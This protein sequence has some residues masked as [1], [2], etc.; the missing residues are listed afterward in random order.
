LPWIYPDDPRLW[1]FL[2]RAQEAGARPL[3]VA[4]KVAPVTFPLLKALGAYAL[5]YHLPLVPPNV[6]SDL[7]RRAEQFGWPPISVKPHLR[8]HPVGDYIRA[9]LAQTNSTK[10]TLP[11]GAAESIDDAANRGFPN[12][13]L[14]LASVLNDWALAAPAIIPSRW[15][16]SISSWGESL[17]A[18]REMKDE[19]S[20]SPDS[21]DIT[22]DRASQNCEVVR[23]PTVVTHGLVAADVDRKTWEE[24]LSK[25]GPSVHVVTSRAATRSPFRPGGKPTTPKKPE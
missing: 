7:P 5:Q 23:A 21:S 22:Q 2:R 13:S 4:R 17:G 19:Q 11:A 16:N 1:D 6:S 25:I 10:W 18:N 14:I 3:L 9:F 20:T 24:A 12:A 15:V 8:R